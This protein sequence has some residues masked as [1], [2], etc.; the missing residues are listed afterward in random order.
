MQGS[1][2]HPWRLALIA[3]AAFFGL[4]AGRAAIAP[5]SSAVIAGAAVVADGQRLEVR[6][7]QG[8]IVTELSVR[9]GQKVDAG[10]NLVLLDDG[11]GLSS[12]EVKLSQL[13]RTAARAARLRAQLD[14]AN[15]IE[16]AHW[17]FRSPENLGEIGEIKQDE[18]R[19][20]QAERTSGA[21]QLTEVL[22]L[23]PHGLSGVPS[24]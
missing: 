16:F 17:S 7:L 15:S 19:V 1:F 20:L 13:R 8:G 9:E 21:S 10:Q 3:I 18:L 2:S 6:S 23:G 14:G 24:M 4:G 22:R 11:A 12:L 5:L